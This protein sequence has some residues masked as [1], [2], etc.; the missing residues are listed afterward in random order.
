MTVGV[1]RF[2]NLGQVRKGRGGRKSGSETA[3]FG[4]ICFYHYFFL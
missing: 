4:N 2:L 3:T 1:F